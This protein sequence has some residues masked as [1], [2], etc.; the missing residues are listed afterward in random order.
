MLSSPSISI[1]HLQR[2][3]C[4][5]L[6]REEKPDHPQMLLMGEYFSKKLSFVPISRFHP[7]ADTSA[8]VKMASRLWNPGRRRRDP[9][10]LGVT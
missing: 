10:V 3:W 2:E 8:S 7:F 4:T 1:S 6:V 5:D 9:L